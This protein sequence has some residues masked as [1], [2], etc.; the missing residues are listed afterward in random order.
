M[1][2]GVAIIVLQVVVSTQNI[3]LQHLW[4]QSHIMDQVIARN[5]LAFHT[6]DFLHELYEYNSLILSSIK[7][8][9]VGL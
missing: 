6:N 9:F 3:C 2:E 5:Y 1:R 8:S 7:S 4:S